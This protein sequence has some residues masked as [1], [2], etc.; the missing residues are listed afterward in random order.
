MCVI[1]LIPSKLW[2]QPVHHCSEQNFCQA[3]TRPSGITHSL[4]LLNSLRIRVEARA[5]TAERAVIDQQIQFMRTTVQLY[6][7][8]D[9]HTADTSCPSRISADTS[10]VLGEEHLATPHN[11]DALEE[12]EEQNTKIA[13]HELRE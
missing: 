10:T 13:I 7:T 8:K 12:K 9:L 6:L 1:C 5:N 2:K 4:S 11:D 3:S